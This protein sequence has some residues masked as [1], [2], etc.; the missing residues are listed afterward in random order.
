MQYSN[1]GLKQ[2]DPSSFTLYNGFELRAET[3]KSNTLFITGHRNNQTRNPKLQK[4]VQPYRVLVKQLANTSRAN[5]FVALRDS[6]SKQH[7]VPSVHKWATSY[8]QTDSLHARIFFTHG[9][10]AKP[11]AA[12]NNKEKSCHHHKA[13]APHEFS[14]LQNTNWAKHPATLSP[15]FPQ[16]LQV[17]GYHVQKT[18]PK[19]SSYRLL[20]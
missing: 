15:Y 9:L 5:S 3:F 14:E 6:I 13:R 4:I 17:T 2:G 16:L 10:F 12:N 20:L 18:R 8:H 19:Y 11:T 1:T 7:S